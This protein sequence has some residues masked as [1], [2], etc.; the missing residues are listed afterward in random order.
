M[1]VALYSF[2]LGLAVFCGLR[3]WVPATA[4]VF[5]FLNLLA[6]MHRD[7]QKDDMKTLKEHVDK[8]KRVQSKLRQML[9]QHNTTLFWMY[10]QRLRN[11]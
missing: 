9:Q 10:K 3:A 5:S 8:L 4:W 11:Y 1:A 6:S 7:H 2:L